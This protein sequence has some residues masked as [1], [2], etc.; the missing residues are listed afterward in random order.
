MSNKEEEKNEKTSMTEEIREYIKE[1]LHLDTELSKV[2][3]I[4]LF[5]ESIGNKLI[6]LYSMKFPKKCNTCQTIYE[7]RNEY[8][9]ATNPIQGRSGTIFRKDNVQEYRNCVC[10][11]TLI[12]VTEDRRDNTIFGRARR[13]LFKLCYEKL[14]EYTILPEN[15]LYEVVREIFKKVIDKSQISDSG[16]KNIKYKDL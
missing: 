2:E 6:K 5:T 16:L 15:E 11:S 7:T 9:E 14:K 4:S 10:G 1:A 12:V 13:D 8:L 3:Q